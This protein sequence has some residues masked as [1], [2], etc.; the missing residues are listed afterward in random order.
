MILYLC[1]FLQPKVGTKVQD[2]EILLL[3]CPSGYEVL[4]TEKKEG[5][6]SCKLGKWSHELQ[7]E[8]GTNLKNNSC[9][10]DM[11]FDLY[12]LSF[13][14]KLSFEKFIF[15]FQWISFLKYRIIFFLLVR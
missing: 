1:T 14:A 7:C 13:S 8:P 2:D 11:A 12:Y 15:H 6:V 3:R 9:N 4:G 5:S 10:S